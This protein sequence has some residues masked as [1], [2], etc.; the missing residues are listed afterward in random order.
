MFSHQQ[1]FKNGSIQAYFCFIFVLFTSQFNYKLKKRRCVW[2][3]N[4]EPKNGGRRRTHRAM[5]SAPKD[6]LLCHLIHKKC[7]IKLT[8]DNI[9]YFRPKVGQKTPQNN[10]GRCLSSSLASSTSML[11]N[12][13][14]GPIL[15][16][17]FGC[18]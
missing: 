2:D 10:D 12:V 14:Q 6:L 1:L 7:F 18:Y 9:F 16:N 15:Q 13:E 3:S 17:C 4:P 11:S 5:S 8:K